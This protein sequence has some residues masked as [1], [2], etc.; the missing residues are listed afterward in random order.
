MYRMSSM[1]RGTSASTEIM[2]M[3][4]EKNNMLFM[5]AQNMNPASSYCVLKRDIH[6][7]WQPLST[8]N[9]HTLE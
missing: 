5:N 9:L 6:I 1:A 3:S 2:N 4:G 7:T 8:L